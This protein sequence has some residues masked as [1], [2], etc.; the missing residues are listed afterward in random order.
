MLLSKQSLSEI[1]HAPSRVMQVRWLCSYSATLNSGTEVDPYHFLSTG[2]LSNFRHLLSFSRQEGQTTE[3]CK[4]S[5]S[6]SKFST[7]FTILFI[8]SA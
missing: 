1:N 8:D 5:A 3:D 2:V 6:L 4:V 7:S